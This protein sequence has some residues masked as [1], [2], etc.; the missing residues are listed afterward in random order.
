MLFMWD[1]NILFE[2]EFLISVGISFQTFVSM[3]LKTGENWKSPLFSQA[4]AAWFLCFW[5]PEIDADADE[6]QYI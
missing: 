5:S 3:N 1:L 2:W 4:Y 6:K